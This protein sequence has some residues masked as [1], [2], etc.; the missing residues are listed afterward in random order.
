MDLKTMI[1]KLF[2]LIHERQYLQL[3]FCDIRNKNVILI[4][5]NRIRQ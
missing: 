1:Y 2:V 5:L 3:Y 4:Q